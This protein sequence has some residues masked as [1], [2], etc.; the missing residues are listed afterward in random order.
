MDKKTRGWFLRKEA[1]MMVKM[2]NPRIRK[3]QQMDRWHREREE[4]RQGWKSML[5]F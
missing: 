5:G 1:H 4:H 3:T 2:N